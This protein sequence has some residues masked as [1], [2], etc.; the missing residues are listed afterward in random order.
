MEADV[1]EVVGLDRRAQAVVDLL[2]L[3]EH[4]LRLRALRSH[5]ARICVGCGSREQ[6]RGYAEDERLRLSS[7]AANQSL[8]RSGSTSAP[9]GAGTSQVGHPSNDFGCLQQLSEPKTD[10][11]PHVP[12]AHKVAGC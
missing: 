2:D 6:E 4:P 5:R 11:F 9:E 7:P 10:H 8:G 1:G 3:A 12:S